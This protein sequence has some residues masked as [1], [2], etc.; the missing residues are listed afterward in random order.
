MSDDPTTR[1]IRREPPPFRRVFVG[2]VEH[3]SPCMIRITFTGPDLAG[4][5]VEQPAASV[6]L[7]LPPPGSSE[8]IVPVWNGNEF[9]MA[10]GTRPTL[11]TLTPRRSDPAEPELDV[12]IVIHEAGAMS[13]WAQAAVEGDPAAISGPGRGYVVDAAAPGFLLAGDETA[14]PAISQLLAAVPDGV[15]LQVHIEIRG[16]DS[17]LALP[18]RVHATVDWHELPGHAPPGT[19][20]VDAVREAVIADGTRVWAAGEA[21]SMQAIRRHLFEQR[22]HPRAQATVRGYWKQGASG[23]ADE[24]P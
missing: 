8:L 7:L 16:P 18:E 20:L 24:S 17:R 15:A 3:L 14:I 13:E 22:L 12:D 5:A 21:A 23:D 4:F 11:R 19:S 9:L 6:R 1:R 10:D 2:A